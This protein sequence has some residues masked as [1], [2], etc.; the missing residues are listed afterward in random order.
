MSC[1]I[2]ALPTAH[3]SSAL[4]NGLFS[5]LKNYHQVKR[6]TSS[7]QYSYSKDIRG[8][9]SQDAFCRH[10]SSENHTQSMFQKKNYLLPLKLGF[11]RSDSLLLVVPF[12][13]L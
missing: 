2:R 10:A 13:P 1:G 8:K 5:K 7:G 4:R 3:V 11:G 9:S 12:E 6:G